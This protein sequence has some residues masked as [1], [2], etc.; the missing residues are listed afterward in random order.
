M[1]NRL[2]K[3]FG[4]ILLFF[5]LSTA[6]AVCQP[7]NIGSPIT[8]NI[9]DPISID[10]FIGSPVCWIAETFQ[11]IGVD[12]DI[13][14]KFRI[15]AGALAV[16]F[17]SLQTYRLMLSGSLDKLSG[18][19]IRVL[20]VTI[21]IGTGAGL[22]SAMQDMWTQTY[23]ASQTRWSGTGGYSDDIK[24]LIDSVALLL[25]EA[26][27][28]GATVEVGGSTPT[29]E[30]GSGVLNGG[31]AISVISVLTNLATI[32][33][34]T[35]F[36][37][38]GAIM[39]LA[40]LQLL[41]VIVFWDICVVFILLPEGFGWFKRLIGQYVSS[42]LKV[43]LVPFMFGIVIEMGLSRP[44]ANM[45]AYLQVGLNDINTTITQIQN[46][47][48]NNA[49]ASSLNIFNQNW[50]NFMATVPASIGDILKSIITILMG[51][52]MAIIG[53]ILGLGIALYI[54]NQF[55]GLITSIFG[56][57]A[58]GGSVGNPVAQ[59]MNVMRSTNLATV[60]A[61][62]TTKNAGSSTLKGTRSVGKNLNPRTWQARAGAV[63][64][65]MG[66]FKGAQ[67]STR[68]FMKTGQMPH[69]IKAAQVAKTAPKAP[70]PT[71]R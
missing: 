70:E 62:N 8:I 52:L 6:L 24:Q 33:I 13:D 32:L 29:A 59:V 9:N 1:M 38:Y 54:L 43:L 46:A 71:K 42:I 28:V 26:F 3:L 25:P 4:F 35:P 66:K 27:Y 58:G 20:V 53:C 14:G 23:N 16:I 67:A 64:S 61:I 15:I 19:V 48:P 30:A 41:V 56:G 2:L 51:W 31:N 65:S 57:F 50:E 21:L 40:G 10:K 49:L 69:Q 17:L 63:D 22:T 5:V 44:L 12:Y 34:L 60:R 37:A 47:M 11:T 18:L 36:M 39:Y 55:A 7:F 45:A 68:E